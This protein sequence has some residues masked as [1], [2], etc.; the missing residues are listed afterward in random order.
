MQ[1]IVEKN[2]E[3][4]KV[5]F[6]RGADESDEDVKLSK[7]RRKKRKGMRNLKKLIKSKSLASLEKDIES[8]CSEGESE[9]DLIRAKEK[10][11]KKRSC[12][13]QLK[14]KMATSTVASLE[15]GYGKYLK[16]EPRKLDENDNKS[17]KKENNGKIISERKIETSQQKGFS[18][19]FKLIKRKE[20]PINLKMSSRIHNKVQELECSLNLSRQENSE[21]LSKF[22]KL[23]LEYSQLRN[24]FEG[25]KIEKE[26]CLRDLE[27][28]KTELKT[29][30]QELK[31]KKNKVEEQNSHKNE[32]QSLI[33]KLKDELNLSINK[34]QHKS[35]IRKLRNELVDITNKNLDETSN[36]K[37]LLKIAQLD[38]VNAKI[39]NYTSQANLKLTQT[40]NEILINQNNELRTE[41]EL[42]KTRNKNLI[43][44]YNKSTQHLSN[45]VTVAGQALAEKEKADK[46]LAE[47]V[48][49]SEVYL[50][51][52][53]KDKE[54]IGDMQEKLRESKFKVFN[55]QN[56]VEEKLKDQEKHYKLDLLK[57]KYKLNQ[58]NSNL[59]E[60]KSFILQTSEKQRKLS[61]SFSAL[62][63][64]ASLETK[65]ILYNHVHSNLVA[66]KK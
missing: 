36:Y 40:E 8:T 18:G 31:I 11:L 51:L 6:Y 25:Q 39:K 61:Q 56:E 1:K 16:F 63:S 29:L 48:A 34:S 33:D 28:V 12:V 59:L 24:S 4:K 3:N 10:K 37:A 19:S 9:N 49:C 17:F 23:N 14:E 27:L 42:L 7:R 62:C 66:G 15:S 22:H 38:L 13:A 64:S 26:N 60:K 2:I 58:I 45:V 53:I 20:D 21:L 65:N 41:V 44:K 50:K 52:R 55:L 43:L 46:I 47:A 35:E 30:Q 57:L 54:F 32:L 5:D